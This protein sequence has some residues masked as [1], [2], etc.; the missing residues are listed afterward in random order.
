MDRNTVA[1]VACTFV[2]ILNTP[3]LLGTWAGMRRDGF[4]EPGRVAL[5]YRSQ[6]H[7]T[8]T[9]RILKSMIEAMVKWLEWVEGLSCMMSP[10]RTSFP[11]GF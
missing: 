8:G 9:V 1:I 3:N 5:E 7:D 6:Q 2:P 11:P 10:S 4:Y